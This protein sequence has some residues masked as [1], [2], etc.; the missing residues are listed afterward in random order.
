[1]KDAR[2]ATRR[3]E[4]PAG[5]VAL[6][7]GAARVCL[8]VVVAAALLTAARA[9]AQCHPAVIELLSRTA[10]GMAAEG[11]SNAPVV[12]ENG[13]VTAYSSNAIDLV[14][15]PM[16]AVRTQVYARD[17]EQVVSQLLSVSPGRQAGNQ[18]SQSSGFP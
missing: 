8:L 5:A 11:S 6:V 14:S 15:P 13:L 16:R 9:S 3:G 17:L 12:N 18:P 10:R 7:P 2:V 4:Q 1:M